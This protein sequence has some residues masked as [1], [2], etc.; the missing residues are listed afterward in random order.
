VEFSDEKE[1]A[2]VKEQKLQFKG[3]DL[4]VMTKAEYYE[5]KNQG[6]KKRKAT[7]KEEHSPPTKKAK[8][9]DF[10]KS[11]VLLLKNLNGEQTTRETLKDFF[12]QY[13]PVAHA[14]YSKGDSEGYL[15]FHSAESAEKCLNDITQNSKELAGK[16]IEASLL[17]G[18]AEEQYF[19]K[20]S[21]FREKAKKGGRGGRGRGGRGRGRGGKKEL[22]PNI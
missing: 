2:G 13:G 5:K 21:Q 4:L 22:I 1:V 6:S 3:V 8:K 17:Q 11:S 10:P 16:K 20:I 9:E 7:E 14:D 18:E 19:K 12:Q 15:R